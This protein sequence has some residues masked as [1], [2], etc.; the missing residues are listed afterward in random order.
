[1]GK[2]EESGGKKKSIFQ[3]EDEKSSSWMALIF[4]VEQMKDRSAW[5][6]KMRKKIKG[7]IIRWMHSWLDRWEEKYRKY[8]KQTL[9]E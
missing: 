9:F 2:G 3:V 7:R 4:L 6:G 8:K 1:M 5:L